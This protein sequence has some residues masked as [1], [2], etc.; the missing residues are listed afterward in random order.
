MGPRLD[1]LRGALTPH[2]RVMVF[3]N[4]A[5]RAADSLSASARGSR[6]V[7]APPELVRYRSIEE[8]SDDGPLYVTGLVPSSNILPWDE[9]RA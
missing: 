7:L 8:V 9:S 5:T 1:R 2:G 3:E 6:P 4:E